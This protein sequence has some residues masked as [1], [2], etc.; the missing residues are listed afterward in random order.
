MAS[1]ELWIVIPNWD[2]FQHYSD[3]DPRW[4]KNY[5]HLLSDDDYLGLSGHCRSILHGLWLVYAS[6][7]GQVRLD[8]RSLS[9]R[10]ALRVSSLQLES[11]NGAGFIEV[12]AS[13][14]LALRYQVAS[15]EKRR[16]EKKRGAVSVGI[17]GSEPDG[18][19]PRLKSVREQV[20][21]SL[22]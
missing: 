22:G 3:R 16:E 17:N 2:E 8:A 21:E 14:P 9:H 5:R 12:S 7:D 11:L 15:L 4:I 6:S 18:P 13:R 20:Q 1:P 19:K 10:L